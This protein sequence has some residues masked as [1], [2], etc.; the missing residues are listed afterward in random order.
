M[1]TLV[2]Y[3]QEL[4]ASNGEVKQ[5]N[6]QLNDAVEEISRLNSLLNDAQEQITTRDNQLKA[7]YDE[8]AILEREKE[9]NDLAVSS[10]F[11]IRRTKLCGI[12]S[13]F[14]AACLR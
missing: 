12:H 6:A 9:T 14:T 1:L 7:A 11:C 10:D 5:L 2:F 4:S 3:F 8:V 13:C